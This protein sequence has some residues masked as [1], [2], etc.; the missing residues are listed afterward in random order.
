MS[1][2][3]GWYDDGSGRQRWWDGTQ[4]TEHFAPEQQPAVPAAPEQWTPDAQTEQYAPYTPPTAQS[5]AAQTAVYPGLAGVPSTTPAEK[6]TPLVG[7]IALGLAV[8]GTIL[9]FF[10][11]LVSIFGFFLLF[12]AFVMSIVGLFLKGNAKWPSIAGL[13]LSVVG[14]II[15]IV[16]FVIFTVGAVQQ[17]S[18]ST[19]VPTSSSSDAPSDAPSDTPS[20]GPTD[21]APS[22]DR[23][24]VAEV[25]EGLAAILEDSGAGD[26]YSQEQLTCTAQFFVDSDI[27]D[28]KLAIIAEGPDALYSDI[29]AATEFTEKFA[30]SFE[31][32]LF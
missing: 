2:P 17:L 25:E 9:A 19:T 32:C 11:P 26:T 13:S 14:T 23:P 27:P 8:V 20:D 1:T 15:G 30:N 24:S 4:W 31:T 18:D 21:A 22:G 16:M 6:K 12:V 3:A 29:E 28:D 10:P 5:P 7:F